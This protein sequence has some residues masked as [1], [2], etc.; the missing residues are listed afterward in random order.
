MP[1]SLR[2]SSLGGFVFPMSGFSMLPAVLLSRHGRFSSGTGGNLTRS[3]PAF[4]YSLSLDAEAK[5]GE[6]VHMRLQ[7][8]KCQLV[9][10]GTDSPV[11]SDSVGRPGRKPEEKESSANKERSA[12]VFK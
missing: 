9:E 3:V 7:V 2:V 12:G 4:D 1:F 8:W 6:T 11:L 5:K 10:A